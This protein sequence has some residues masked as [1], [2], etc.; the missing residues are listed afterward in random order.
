MYKIIE[1]KKGENF[2][3]FRASTIH[4][5]TL[6]DKLVKSGADVQV[7]QDVSGKLNPGVF[8][9]EYTTRIEE[10]II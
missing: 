1:Y 3:H 2:E 10:N 8:W 4:A 6:Y 9:K 5:M 7:F